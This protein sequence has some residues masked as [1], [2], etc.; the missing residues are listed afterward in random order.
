MVSFEEKTSKL[1]F[2]LS[3]P[4]CNAEWSIEDDKRGDSIKKDDI[5]CVRLRNREWTS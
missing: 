1:S 4:C 5:S 3:A 2:A